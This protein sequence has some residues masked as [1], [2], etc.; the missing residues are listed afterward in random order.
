MAALSV[1]LGL[2][3]IWGTYWLF[4]LCILRILFFVTPS[5]DIRWG[6]EVGR[7][8]QNCGKK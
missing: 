8:K 2:G 7:E 6:N 5:P 4:S 1:L 3:S